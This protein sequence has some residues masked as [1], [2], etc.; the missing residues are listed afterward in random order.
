MGGAGANY[1]NLFCRGL[2]LNGYPLRVL[3]LKGFAFGNHK[4]KGPRHNVTEYG[5]HYSYLGFT[6]RPNFFIFKLFD[7]SL[8]VLRLII[9]LVSILNRRRSI[10]LLVYNDE[11]QTNIPI[12]FISQLFRI[13]KITFVPEFYDKS[14][15][16]GSI[17]KKIRWYGFLLNFY[18]INKHS[19]KLIVFSHFLKDEY[20]KQGFDRKNIIVQPNL[21]DFEFW[22]TKNVKTKFSI[23]YSGTPSIKDGLYDL[24]EAISLLQDENIHISL[25]VVGDS[26][27]GASLIP[28]LEIECQ[29]LGILRKVTFK[30]LVD[31]NMV[32]QYL[33]ECRILAITR[34]STL[35]TKAGFPTKLGEYLSLERPVLSTDF[36][37]IKT[38]FEDGIDIVIAECGNPKSIA[39]KIKWMTQNNQDLEMIS[40]NAYKKAKELFEFNKSVFRIINFIN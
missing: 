15:F 29:K 23:G 11:I 24:F 36:G 18:Y 31:S 5:I 3:L 6:Q 27:F 40:Q 19:D 25:V 4:N 34:P 7:D 16:K 13:R 12:H 20:V 10:S 1:L 35:Q 17:F 39:Q 22:K 30:G 26:T 38:Y 2:V 32:K 28:D 37:D 8:S 9:F 14:D 33:S 21:V